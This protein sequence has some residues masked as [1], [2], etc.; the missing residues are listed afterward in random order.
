MFSASHPSVDFCSFEAFPNHGGLR[1]QSNLPAAWAA[2]FYKFL[3]ESPFLLTDS[4]HSQS[5]DCLC[6][7][8]LAGHAASVHGV[9]F[10]SGLTPV[11]LCGLRMGGKRED[12]DASLA[13]VLP[14]WVCVVSL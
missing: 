12:A 8:P 1:Y 3:C 9:I 7:Y 2:T 5:E 14:H 6:F 11:F 4:S 10:I 13:C